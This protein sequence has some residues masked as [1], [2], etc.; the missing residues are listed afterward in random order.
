MRAMAWAGW[1]RDLLA[2]KF[3]ELG[4]PKK[5]KEDSNAK[6]KKLAT[7]FGVS[8]NVVHDGEGELGQ[9]HEGRDLV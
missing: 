7:R 8:G 9:H 3:R 6:K 4:F 1:H 5:K 2:D